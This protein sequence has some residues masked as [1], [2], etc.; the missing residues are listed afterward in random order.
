[1]NFQTYLLP[2]CRAG[3][4]ASSSDNFRNSSNFILGFCTVL[5][6]CAGI[7]KTTSSVIIRFERRTS[8]GLSRPINQ[9]KYTAKN[10]K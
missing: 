6:T 1:M 10:E 8:S 4:H 2:I 9:V 3:S 5:L 7:W